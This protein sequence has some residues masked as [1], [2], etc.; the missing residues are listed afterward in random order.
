MKAWEIKEL[1]ESVDTEIRNYLRA[2]GW[3]ETCETPGSYYVWHRE[4]TFR[5]KSAPV[6]VDVKTAFA[7]QS[8]LNGDQIP[9]ETEKD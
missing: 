9:P 8:A 6:L 1:R 5:G 7:I 4:L 2:N 3:E